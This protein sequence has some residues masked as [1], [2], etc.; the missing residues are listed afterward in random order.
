MP[1]GVALL[2][3]THQDHL[4]RLCNPALCQLLE[5]PREALEG[6]PLPTLREPE[7]PALSRLQSAL[8]SRQ[9]A[10]ECL[11]LKAR[12]KP[13]GVRLHLQPV[14]DETSDQMLAVHIPLEA[15]NPFEEVP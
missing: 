10:S 6:H 9:V 8:A 2:D 14:A 11:R 12:D 7:S 5:I 3:L 13:L 1:V 4:I 15:P